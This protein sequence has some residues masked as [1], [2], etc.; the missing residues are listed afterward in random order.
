MGKKHNCKQALSPPRPQHVVSHLLT[1]PVARR[2]AAQRSPDLL[3]C[4]KHR[5]LRKAP[6]CAPSLRCLSPAVICQAVLAMLWLAPHG[7]WL[8][9]GPSH[10]REVSLLT[11]YWDVMSFYDPLF[12]NCCKLAADFYCLKFIPQQLDSWI[13]GGSTSLGN[14]GFYAIIKPAAAQVS[15]E[16][17]Y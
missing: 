13:P 17:G 11:I 9:A 15:G 7:S 5:S 3:A 2:Y 4:C 6:Q 8:C 10:H 14:L 16:A 1:A 12:L